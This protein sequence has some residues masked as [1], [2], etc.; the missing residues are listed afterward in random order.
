[1]SFFNAV[2]AG[3]ADAVRAALD[4]DP[5]RVGVRELALDA[6]GSPEPVA[7]WP[8]A[9]CL[10]AA[11]GH[12]EVVELLLERGA[13]P[14][15]NARWGY[16]AV[17]HAAW[18]G[19]TE[20]VELLLTHPSTRPDV[21]AYGLGIDVNNAARQ[22]WNE[23]VAAHLRRDPLAVHRRGVVGETPLHWAAHNG[24]EAVCVALLDA[25]AEIDADELGLYGG[26]PLHWAAEKEAGIV[27]LLLARGAA[28][29]GRNTLAARSTRASRRF[30]G[31]RAKRTTPS[32]A[33]ACCSTP[34]P[35]R[36]R[37]TRPDATPRTGPG[38]GGPRASALHWRRWAWSRRGGRSGDAG[39][40]VLSP[41]PPPDATREVPAAPCRHH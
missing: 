14:L 5:G 41:M 12:T 35:T 1:M 33:C 28:V 10:A 26:K 31:A 24:E 15:E 34:A 40:I 30:S 18:G 16:P 6:A 2:R 37:W 25:G 11:G 38:N 20:L 36:T 27:R 17:M 4:E 22:G 9:L 7:G 23:L 39:W 29:D 32:R 21:P 3:D 13:D 19:H 8:T